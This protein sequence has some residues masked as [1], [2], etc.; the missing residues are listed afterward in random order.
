M[1]GS[2]DIDMDAL[3]G[4]CGHCTAKATM[5]CGGCMNMEYCSEECEEAD[6]RLHKLICHQLSTFAS[7]PNKE[8]RRAIFLP[9]DATQPTFMSLPCHITEASD[10]T[11][12]DGDSDN[13]LDSVFLSK[14]PADEEETSGKDDTER[15]CSDDDDDI[16]DYDEAKGSCIADFCDPELGIGSTTLLVFGKQ[17][18]GQHL[19]HSIYLCNWWKFPRPLVLYALTKEYDSGMAVDMDTTGLTLAIEVLVEMKR[20][21]ESDLVCAFMPKP[22][23]KIKGVRVKAAA[24]AVSSGKQVFEEIDVPLKHPVFLAGAGSQVSKTL[25]I[26]LLTHQYAEGPGAVDG[27]NHKEPHVPAAYL[28]LSLDAVIPPSEGTFSAAAAAI[29]KAWYD[30]T[31]SMFIVRSDTKPL[32]AKTV[33]QMCHFCRTEVISLLREHGGKADAADRNMLDMSIAGK[34]GEMQRKGE[35]ETRKAAQRKMAEAFRGLDM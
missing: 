16:P 12:E 35:Q 30:S 21:N 3:N 1:S 32:T 25:G 13:E 5:M 34:W 14:A 27:S 7:P 22:P 4:H 26:P 33:K 11:V 9:E 6:K 24:D 15:E 29:P 2:A 17:G 23:T 18:S 8:F 20:Y 10:E 28:H 19:D 31:A